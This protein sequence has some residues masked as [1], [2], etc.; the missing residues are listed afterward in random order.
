M[1]M[2]LWAHSIT[3]YPCSRALKTLFDG[4]LGKG[5]FL[6]LVENMKRSHSDL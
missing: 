4:P 3:L 2:I 1:K 6:H 5:V